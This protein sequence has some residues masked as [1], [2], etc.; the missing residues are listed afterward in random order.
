M[1]ETNQS[2]DTAPK[3]GLAVEP[4]NLWSE[5]QSFGKTLKI[6]SATTSE[7]LA[8]YQHFMQVVSAFFSQPEIANN[9]T[10]ETRSLVSKLF[11]QHENN[12]SDPVDFF[13]KTA[14]RLTDEVLNKGYIK[15]G[16]SRWKDEM[17]FIKDLSR[18]ELYSTTL[19]LRDET[20]CQE[21]LVQLAGKDSSEVLNTAL[22]MEISS[23]EQLRQKTQERAIS[24]LAQ[25][26]LTLAA[27]VSK[28]DSFIRTLGTLLTNYDPA[29]IQAALSE[30][31]TFLENPDGTS[32]LDEI[33]RR[34]FLKQ[35]KNVK[36]ILKDLG[37]EAKK[38]EF[39]WKQWVEKGIIPATLLN[40]FEEITT[41]SELADCAQVLSVC[42]KEVKAKYLLP[43]LNKGIDAG[44]LIEIAE[45]R[46]EFSEDFITSQIDAFIHFYDVSKETTKS[47]KLRSAAG[48]LIVATLIVIAATQF[49]K[50]DESVS[51][52]AKIESIIQSIP[53]ATPT[54]TPT[55]I[56]TATSTSTPTFIPPTATETLTP[57]PTHTPTP[58][59]TP[60]P[61]RVIGATIKVTNKDAGVDTDAIGAQLS[62][63]VLVL[64]VQTS[65]FGTPE[66]TGQQS[67]SPSIAESASRLSSGIDRPSN[68]S[69]EEFLQDLQIEVWRIEGNGIEGHYRISTASYFQSTEHLW[70]DSN[71]ANINK[72]TLLASQKDI[73]ISRSSEKISSQVLNLPVK[74][75]FAVTENGIKIKGDI[76]SFKVLQRA[77]GTYFVYF[78]DKTDIGKTISISV[79]LGRVGRVESLVIPPP[80]QAELQDMTQNFIHLNNLKG[81]MKQVVESITF[82][83]KLSTLQKAQMLESY[84]QQNFLYSLD[85]KW[86]D[87]YDQAK[88][89]KTFFERIAEI[90]KTDC[91]MANTAL[92]F[93][94]R[95]QG[96][97][98]RM[99]LGFANGGSNQLTK[100]QYHGWVEAYIDGRWV[101]FDATP[102]NKDEFTEKALK[103][104]LPPGRVLP[105]QVAVDIEGAGDLTVITTVDSEVNISSVAQ[106]VSNP[107][108]GVGRPNVDSPE[109]FL[110]ALKVEIWQVEGKIQE[111]AGHYRSG[112]SAVFLPDNHEWVDRDLT[113]VNKT[114]FFAS[115]KDVTLS[116]NS[117]TISSQV[118]NIPVRPDFAVTE[119]GIKINGISA[120]EVHQR[121]NGTYFIYF[122]NKEDVGKTISV[123]ID[124]GR[125]DRSAIPAPDVEQLQDMTK[126]FISLNDMPNDMRQFV[127]QINQ[128]NITAIQKAQLLEGYIKNKFLYSLDTSLNDYYHNG[129]GAAG[130]FSRIAEIQKADCDMANTVL[131]FLLRNQGIPARM[132]L[133]FANGE[134]DYS[135]NKLSAGE[136]H[137]WVEAYINGQWVTLD[138]TP[139]KRDDFTE[140]AL[141][142]KLPLTQP[143][144]VDSSVDQENKLTEEQ[145]RQFS[146]DQTPT[147]FTS[148]L[149]QGQPVRI[150]MPHP[151]I[152]NTQEK[153]LN[154]SV[155]SVEKEQNIVEWEALNMLT[156]DRS[157]KRDYYRIATSSH[158]N[159]NT[160]AWLVDKN[161][162][163]VWSDPD[164]S[165]F[166]LGNSLFRTIKIQGYDQ[167]I[168]LPIDNSNLLT[169]EI[170]LFYSNNDKPVGGGKIP[171][172]SIFR[173]YDGT[174]FLMHLP[175]EYYGKEVEVHVN[176]RPR[177]FALGGGE[178]SI[179]APQGFVL[180][181]M[182]DQLIG[183]GG[184]IDLPLDLGTIHTA[185][186]TLNLPEDVQSFLQELNNRGNLSD[187][188][189]ARVLEGYIQTT[190]L[191]S[192]NPDWSTFYHEAKDQ[193]SFI[194]RI[195]EIKKTDSTVAN[196]ALIALLRV[197]GISSRMAFGYAGYAH[198]KTSP[199]F[200]MNRFTAAEKRGWVEAYINAKWLTLDATPLQP[201]AYTSKSTNKVPAKQE[202]DNESIAAL[203]YSIR[204]DIA[205]YPIE[206]LL[207]ILTAMNAVA[208]GLNAAGRIKN[209]KL[210]KHVKSEL[211]RRLK[212]YTGR[213]TGQLANILSQAEHQ[214]IDDATFEQRIPNLFTLIPPFAIRDR[215]PTSVKINRLAEFPYA[216][217]TR[218]VGK[219]SEPDAAQF[220]IDVLG[221]GEKEI[222]ERIQKEAFSE[223]KSQ[224]RNALRNTIYN[225][226][227]TYQ[228]QN[229]REERVNRKY[230]DL[231]L[232]VVNAVV[233]PNTESEWKENTDKAKEEFYSK[234]IK[235]YAEL[236]KPESKD[237]LP[238]PLTKDEIY[239]SLDR[240]FK[241]RAAM[242]LAEKTYQKLKSI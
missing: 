130:F 169:N 209:M 186:N 192:L 52:Q 232:E 210:S 45:G 241:L 87:Y 82:N 231:A 47:H 201:D 162:Y 73:T 88:D 196:T 161:E 195:F 185:E 44:M 55:L 111:L 125:I 112:T 16:T 93:L 24:L 127:S 19:S 211:T 158:L 31:K 122:P 79:D 62:R 131:V 223:I 3:V 85:T 23:Q 115:G 171:A 97:P 136:A 100:G 168:E 67:P 141:K 182:K 218:I 220:L 222:K 226:F 95:N 5:F 191:Y 177:K 235:E 96:I 1:I 197:N 40:S 80:N 207:K 234:Y 170:Y 156:T 70:V 36:N 145:I 181:N 140:K 129:V 8:H 174:Y 138:A 225:S 12:T 104:K 237:T 6:D 10:P 28:R 180:D 213:R 94:L 108:S 152:P 15:P 101:T 166:N 90:R 63:D 167:I 21:R 103:D 32:T 113:R 233:L 107:E 106:T 2:K 187:E 41:L 78:P 227:R 25:Q 57:K 120:Y 229:A 206:A 239:Q 160:Q 165:S 35:H 69:A 56:P 7:R 238:D 49:N 215:F 102:I 51:N 149:G 155:E 119:D 66:R 224:L 219:T 173:N 164:P 133:G 89:A 128:Q 76:S 92:V 18:Q 137:G 184:L 150:I 48:A 123:S 212:D 9:P 34:L 228:Y 74:G 110:A 42:P 46:F 13:V 30:Y 176:F 77:D 163:S 205:E 22:Q 134:L 117:E 189:K 72:T 194:K 81:D 84:I 188:D 98:A 203:L 151:Y 14:E 242:L 154:R 109:G 172:G 199:D 61:E 4:G 71:I 142:D 208:Y 124:L 65:G 11:Y 121:T 157:D 54:S 116:R 105:S 114:T 178:P 118:L 20:A 159:P 60:T 126:N 38:P 200:E 37:E 153:T 179:P 135:L 27:D 148:P 29:Q 86:N 214:R 230:S 202:K 50:T 147:V 217:G 53:T 175:E 193:S 64:Q 216:Q 83:N 198:N 58:T 75:D 240:A 143:P 144:S 221:Y 39:I 17:S 33:K 43:F 236:K 132:A 190:F 68:N 99:A 91:D 139:V 26:D 183:S 204:D 146:T 59:K